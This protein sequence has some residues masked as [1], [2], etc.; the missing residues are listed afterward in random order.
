MRGKNSYLLDVM[1]CS[2]VE[3][4]RRFG[5]NYC[6]YF[7]VQSVDQASARRIILFAACFLLDACMI[8]FSTPE[9]E[10]STFLRN[11][12]KLLSDY[13]VSNLRRH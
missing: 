8:L 13:M 2:V 12:R 6:A 10:G 5:G 9:D 4:Y 3:V 11:I 1:P 7:Q